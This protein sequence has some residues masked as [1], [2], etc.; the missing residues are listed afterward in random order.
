[1]DPFGYAVL[2]GVTVARV[3]ANWIYLG[4]RLKHN[5]NIVSIGERNGA[6]SDR[7]FVRT[8]LFDHCPVTRLFLLVCGY[9]RAVCCFNWEIIGNWLLIS[10]MLVWSCRIRGDHFATRLSY[11]LYFLYSGK[12]AMKDKERKKKRKE[13]GKCSSRTFTRELGI[14]LA[15]IEQ[16]LNSAFQF[17]LI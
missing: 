14:N 17:N 16:Q 10:P 6:W 4:S 3:L 11:F 2:Y 15:W 12:N 8:V 5:W 1:M 7:M 9:R 13:I